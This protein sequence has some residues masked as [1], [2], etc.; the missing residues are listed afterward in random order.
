[1]LRVEQKLND[2]L[3][4]SFICKGTVSFTS[5]DIL[6]HFSWQWFF[7]RC[8]PRCFLCLTLEKDQRMVHKADLVIIG[9]SVGV[10][11]GVLIAIL[12]YFGVRWYKR[13]ANLQR[14]ANECSVAVLPIRTNGFGTSIDT[15]AS[16]SN[17]VVIKGLDYNTKNLHRSWW[18][19]HSK[20]RLP[21]ASGIQRYC[22]KYVNL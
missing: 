13:R 5:S 10:A 21:S 4:P 12:V 1:M 22:Y 2:L 9:I 3:C 18:N 20:D 6:L 17:S 15:S 14:C 11:F 19:H 8:S 16:L 7:A